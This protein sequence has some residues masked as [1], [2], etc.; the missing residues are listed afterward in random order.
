[1][2]TT[3]L[4]AALLRLCAT[5][6]TL[7]VAPAGLLF[8][9]A[10]VAPAPASAQDV[11]STV[12]ALVESSM[13]NYDMLMLAEAQA[14]LDQAISIIGAASVQTPAAAQAWI[15][16]GVV[17]YALSGDSTMALNPFVEA[18][19]IDYDAEI[20]A[21]YATPTLMEIMAQ[22]RMVVPAPVE[23]SG[24]AA[25]GP[26]PV[27]SPP[28]VQPPTA[29]SGP[30]IVHTQV[31]Q[32]RSGE[33]ISIG[34]TIRSEVPFAR[35]MI[36]FRALRDPN[37][38]AVDM[39]PEVD[40][41]TFYGEIPASAGDGQVQLEYFI[42]IFDAQGQQMGSTATEFGPYTVTLT[43]AYES[44]DEISRSRGRDR[45][46]NRD[47]GD[48]SS[49]GRLF[50][51][52]LGLGTGV[53]LATEDP[54][55]NGDDVKLDPGL[56]AT[57]LHLYLE[58]GIAPMRGALHIVPFLRLQMVSL[59]TGIEPEPLG[60]LKIRYFLGDGDRLRLF[61]EGGAG[62][63]NV[64]HFVNLPDIDGGVID[65]TVEGAGHIGGGVGLHYAF[66]DT[67]GFFSE[68]YLMAMFP[69]TSVQL[70][71]N[72]GLQLSF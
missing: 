42:S 56:A 29:P 10:L 34:A 2:R 38:Y 9:S 22:A 57:W 69:R 66:S 26:P 16:R 61:A 21:F 3:R 63:G 41:I 32:A 37:F 55:A 54:R 8:A 13:E 62:V 15:M 31:R 44:P 70:D 1:M 65:T 39:V 40:R 46:R 28:P 59:D 33:A 48:R 50:H 23:P 45:S 27:V 64:V 5:T 60:G 51:P 68:A 11:A 12:A 53:G 14:D 18:L 52:T 30:E 35:A 20:N 47:R 4:T 49:D 24:P 58:L 25:T 71:V 19:L 72:V 36:N 67:A 43:G 6:L 17:S 7:I